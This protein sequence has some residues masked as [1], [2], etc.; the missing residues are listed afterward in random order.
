MLVEG[1]NLPE[2]AIF[3]ALDGILS[4]KWT[5]AQTAAFLTAMKI[6]GETPD[7]LSAA[8]RALR[9]KATPLPPISDKNAID[10]CGTG[11]DGI[12][13]FN[14]STAAAF[15]AAGAG[16]TVAKHGNRAVS[17]TSGSSDILA[18]LGMPLD[19]SPAA[20]AECINNIGI[21]FMFAPNHHP[22]MKHVAGVRRELGTRTM[23]NLLGPLINPAG[24][25]RQLIGVF[26]PDLL[27]PYAKTLA[28][29]GNTR[30]MVVHGDGLDEITIAGESEIAEIKDGAVIRYTIKPEDV[31][32]SSASLS[33]LLVSSV[34]ESEAIFLA[35]LEGEKGAARDIVLLNA[36]AA[37]LVADWA[38]DFPRCRQPSGGG[39]RPRHRQGKTQ[40]FFTPC[41]IG[42]G[43]MARNRL[44]A[45][46]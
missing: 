34:E 38:K 6:K 21:G 45:I 22:A 20:V 36:A 19:L 27:I 13:T 1:R 15:V 23:F 41:Q 32:L 39:H 31:G 24:V 11:G 43:I 17:S 29:L 40:R 44:P 16:A 2:D 28:A 35:V 14:I 30:S 8:A 26:S 33:G 3:A 25:G 37:L 12:G 10:V 4:G 42:Q 9:I 5:M 7:E 46:P 18:K